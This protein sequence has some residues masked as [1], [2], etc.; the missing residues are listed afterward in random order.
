MILACV[1]PTPARPFTHFQDFYFKN[2]QNHITTVDQLSLKI[3]AKII[4][5]ENWRSVHVVVVIC[6]HIVPDSNLK[7]SSV[8]LPVYKVTQRSI[9][10]S[11]Y[12]NS[13]V[14][15]VIQCHCENYKLFTS[16]GIYFEL[17][18]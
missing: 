4:I 11:V 12:A 6:A 13:V 1:R 16:H 5:I 17:T 10:R 7:T 14:S 8:K 18:Y 15:H 3:P 2:I 9:E